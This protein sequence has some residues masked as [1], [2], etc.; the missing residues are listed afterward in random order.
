MEKVVKKL[1]KHALP[2]LFVLFVLDLGGLVW[3]ARTQAARYAMLDT[4]LDAQVELLASTTASLARSVE[5]ISQGL[6]DART[7]S[8]AAASSLAS[9]LSA[10]Q[11]K[12]SSFQNQLQNI[13]ST[14]G[15]LDKLSKTD[16]ELLKK[17]S[18]VYFLNEH[19]Q[20]NQ[21]LPINTKYLYHD[22]RPESVLAEILPN[23]SKLLDDAATANVTIYVKSAYRSFVD[24]AN[25]KGQ[26]SVLYGVGTAN[27]FSA[28]QGY[29]EHQLGTTIDFI[30]TG[31][32]GE[33]TGFDKTVAYL[34]LQNNAY[35]YGFVLSYPEGNKYY[36]FEP[37]HWRF[38]GKAL[39][40]RLHNEGKSFY[41]A[42]QRVID[43]YLVHIF[44][45]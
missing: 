2:I 22:T 28:D 29:S 36:V 19:Y 21:V 1:I 24:Q 13:D 15:T 25:L 16:S 42:D 38:V 33:L 20:P 3:Q 41:D 37:W 45:N 18:K 14:V 44:D 43:S 40:L 12:V 7:E 32:G 35:K 39:A 6:T 5:L 9:R 27:Q 31:T 23:V 17:Y 10:E 30:T 4:K 34:W 26:Y 8:S 11:A